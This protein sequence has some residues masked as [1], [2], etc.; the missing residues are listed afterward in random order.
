MHHCAC[1]Y[2]D[3]TL[4][5][6]YIISDDAE[7]EFDNRQITA[8]VGDNGMGKSTLVYAIALA[9]SGYKKGEKYQSYVRSGSS[10]GIGL[11]L[12]P[13]GLYCNKSFND[14]GILITDDSTGNYHVAM[15]WDKTNSVVKIYINGVF[16]IDYPFSDTQSNG[17]FFK[18]NEG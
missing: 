16:K 7:I 3:F 12:R 13:T 15:C 9:F 4:K 6:G 2:I 17:S 1:A 5:D 18:I 11:S 8:F 10:Y 14:E